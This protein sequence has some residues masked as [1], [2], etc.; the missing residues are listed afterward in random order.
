[1]GI[2]KNNKNI[3]FKFIKD[4]DRIEKYN[5]IGTD[6]FIIDDEKMVKRSYLI[7]TIIAE[8]RKT[9]GY[10]QSQIAESIGIAQNTYSKYENG[11]IFPNVEILVR[12]ADIFHVSLDFMCAR[13]EQIVLEK[14]LESIKKGLYEIARINSEK[15]IERYQ[16]ENRKLTEPELIR[17]TDKY[18]KEISSSVKDEMQ[19][20]KKSLEIILIR[21]EQCKKDYEEEIE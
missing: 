21:I 7:G 18:K 20:I 12:I 1:M 19:F 8:L 15:E 11:V 4:Q 3:L 5:K 6:Y 14:E 9:Y 10:T 17:I 2:V 16:I 13:T